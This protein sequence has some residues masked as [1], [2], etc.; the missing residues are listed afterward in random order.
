MQVGINSKMIP[1]RI[2]INY[3]V[4]ILKIIACTEQLVSL[5]ILK[6]H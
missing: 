5:K 4:H 6:L 2:N 1:G 3:N